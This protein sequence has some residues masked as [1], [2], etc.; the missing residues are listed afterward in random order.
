MEGFDGILA[1]V[2]ER[3]RSR[4]IF[5]L[6]PQKARFLSEKLK[7]CSPSL[8]VECGTAIGY[9]GLHIARALR[10]NGKGRLITVE[11]DSERA[12]E[13]QRN[14][15]RAGMDDIVD[16]RIGDAAVELP[17]I[18]AQVDF[19]FLDNNYE[20]YYPCFRAIERNLTDGALI[21]A[22]NVGV[23]SYGMQSYLDY[24]RGGFESR[25]VWF[26]TDLPWL[27]RDAMEITIFKSK[28][29]SVKE[30]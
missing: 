11:I 20:N 23:G 7:E 24:V 9:S 10:E 15:V 17:S 14:F 16:S 8:V 21:L 18:D 12:R 27:S 3:C 30:E 13:A 2:E 22:D 29:R 5:M 26:D 25:T 19:L 6:G 4:Y 28:S 1:E